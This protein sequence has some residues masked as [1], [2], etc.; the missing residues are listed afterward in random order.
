MLLPYA[1]STRPAEV[2]GRGM[3]RTEGQAGDVRPYHA[4]VQVNWR[5]AI[6]RAAGRLSPR[7]RPRR[8][9]ALSCTQFEIEHI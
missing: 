9:L 1:G 5:S 6:V 8:S 3:V 7:V 2:R 4:V